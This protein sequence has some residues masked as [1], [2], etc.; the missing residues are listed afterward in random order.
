MAKPPP[1][2]IKVV[3]L[4]AGQSRR[5]GAGPAKPWRSL[6]GRPVLGHALDAFAGDARIAGGVV[7]A[8]ADALGKA[9]ELLPDGG[10]SAVAGG[11]GRG[12]SARIGLEA[13]AGDAPDWVLIHDA[14]R[15]FVP[16]AVLD[17][18]IAALAG[19]AEAAIP[20]LEAADSLKRV[21]VDGGTVTG[22]VERGGIGRAQTPQGFAFP[23]ILDLH[24]RARDGRADATDDSSLAEDAG[25]AVA[26]V[27]GD[28]A[29][30]K[31]T[32]GADL[33]LAEAQA[34]AGA[35]AGALAGTGAGGGET[36]LATGFDVHRFAKGGKGIMLGGVALEHDAGIDAHS[37]GDVVLHALADA[38]FGL[39][40][41]GDIG[42]HFPD[43]DDRWK[44]AD[45]A[46]FLAEAA[47]RL[48]AAGGTVLFADTTVIAEAPKV[49]PHRD[50]MRERIA[51]ILG[52]EAGR[53]SVK[54]TTTE[55]LGV[56]GG[57]RGIAAQAAVTAR[58]PR[59]GGDG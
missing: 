59:P 45:S 6:A 24:R 43:S 26:A 47:G 30:A 52:L 19:G 15:P 36:R 49:A 29:L 11:A 32:T 27:A 40:A 58:F 16:A 33:A 21:D 5:L 13:L 31:I 37:D 4:A 17:R 38:V 23:L 53:V 51:G 28:P 44:G 12:D 50:A 48:R 14:A 46:R 3:L 35:G 57:G 39:L 2:T 7:V 10:W 1:A 20:V 55:G 22:R 18:V 41:D 42:A 8:A 34:L 54:A 9:G 56:T 25:V